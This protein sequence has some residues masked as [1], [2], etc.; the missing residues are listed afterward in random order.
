MIQ[1]LDFNMNIIS[2]YHSG[3]QKI[4]LVS[5]DWMVKNSYCPYCGN[6]LLKYPNNKPVADF[7]CK[8]CQEDFELKSKQNK[9]GIKIADGAYN[10][11]LE[12]LSSDKNPH[13]FF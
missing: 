13:F 12:R 7:F 11:M 4:R 1:S 10:T 2:G 5:E 3:S 6:P 9:L 8:L